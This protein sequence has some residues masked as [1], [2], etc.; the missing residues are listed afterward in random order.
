MRIILVLAI[1]LVVVNVLLFT[2]SFTTTYGKMQNNRFFGT[3]SS[4]DSPLRQQYQQRNVTYDGC[5]LDKYPVLTVPK[6]PKWRNYTNEETKR[7]MEILKYVNQIGL[8]THTQ[9]IPPPV[10]SKLSCD[11]DSPDIKGVILQYKRIWFIGDS[12]LRQVFSVLIAQLFPDANMTDGVAEGPETNNVAFVYNHSKG[13]TQLRYSKSGYLWD[14]NE[15]SLYMNEF[16]DAIRTST[17]NDAIIINR[18]HH[19]D[20]QLGPALQ[21]AVDFI[22]N[23][24]TDAAIFFIEAPDEQWPTSNGMFTKACMWKCKCEALNN[25]RIAGRGTMVDHSKHNSSIIGD[26]NLHSY[27]QDK[28]LRAFYESMYPQFVIENTSHSL[29]TTWVPSY[30]P[31]TWKNDMV[32]PILQKSAPHIKIVPIWRQLVARGI[33]HGRGDGDC[34]HKSLNAVLAIGEQLLRAMVS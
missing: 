17:T 11:K 2:I 23:A 20:H 32:N 27:Q 13:S 29:F 28:K 18:S 33:E 9:N 22:A 16:Q 3:M 14:P 12:V 15:R 21:K 5:G 24:T 8:D 1:F 10:F 19:Y 26:L 30:L 31:A 25:D 4:K 7:Y 6:L 34:T